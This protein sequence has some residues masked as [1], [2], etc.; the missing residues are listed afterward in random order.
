[1][2][3]QKEHGLKPDGKLGPNTLCFARE[4]IKKTSKTQP[5]DKNKIAHM[6]SVFEGKPWSVNRDG[7]FRGLFGTNHWAYNKT[8]IGLSFGSHQFTQSGG[9][10][11]QLLKK[12]YDKNPEKFEQ[13]F[14]E[15][16]KELLKVTNRIAGFTV[17]GRNRRVQPVG[18]VDLW[19]NYW[20]DRFV[21]AGRDEEFQECQLELAI[22]N[23]MN[24]AL[25][26]AK[27]LGI[28]TERGIAI[29]FDR[30]IQH[31]PSGAKKLFNR[32]IKKE[33]D[34]LYDMY[35]RHTTKRWSHRTYKLWMS[36]ELDDHR[37]Q[38]T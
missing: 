38:A 33:A 25:K 37:Y 24:P 11:G 20:V 8:H 29:L 1:M 36:D 7:E 4:L 6:I 26:N 12:M 18:G 19:E 30:S 23:Y 15:H 31:G 2:N 28:E 13:Y 5:L 35:R 10:L 9:A 22:E 16:S 32:K 27:S 21:R 34:M 17:K 14:G 3:F